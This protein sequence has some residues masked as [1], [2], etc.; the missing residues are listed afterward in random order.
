MKK[1][2]II[3]KDNPDI[4]ILILGINTTITFKALHILDWNGFISEVTLEYY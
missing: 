4:A 1:K 3:N 2:H